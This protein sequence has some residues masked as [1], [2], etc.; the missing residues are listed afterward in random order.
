[1]GNKGAMACQMGNTMNSIK[2]ICE[3][4]TSVFALPTPALALFAFGA[5]NTRRYDAK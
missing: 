4:V 1:M 3:S 5:I 2:P